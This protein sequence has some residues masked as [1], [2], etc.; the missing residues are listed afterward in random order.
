MSAQAA[1]KIADPAPASATALIA[2]ALPGFE[3]LLQNAVAAVR[4]L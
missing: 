3:T 2:A 4:A 1:V